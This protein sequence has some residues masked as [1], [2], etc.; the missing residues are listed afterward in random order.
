MEIKDILKLTADEIF[1]YIIKNPE[2]END[3]LNNLKLKDRTKFFKLSSD[4][5]SYKLNSK[6][7]A[8]LKKDVLDNITKDKSIILVDTSKIKPNPGQPR[9]VFDEDKLRE[10]SESVKEHGLLQPI[11]VVANNN[12]TFTLIAGERRLRAHKLANIAEIKAIVLDVDELES[13]KL[14]IIENLHRDDLSAMELGLSYLELQKEGGYSLR[15]LE[16]IVK[17]DK[18]YIA[19]RIN[20]TR[21]DDDCVDFILK[22]NINN[23][24]KLLRILETEGT[25][26][27]TLLEKL[28]KN[29][30]KNED[31]EK[32]NVDKITKLPDE[33]Q[34]QKPS[35]QADVNHDKFD[36]N[37]SFDNDKKA[38]NMEAI[39]EKVLESQKETKTDNTEDETIVKQTDSF[40]IKSHGD[41][42]NITINKTKITGKDLEVILESIKAI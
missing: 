14:A 24:S 20:L 8:A 41:I 22:Q 3:I 37:P 15:D 13:R 38:A 25:V 18:N 29:E 33:K 11:V 30:L 17:K 35:K 28:S 39:T 12:N 21:F 19:A 4:L 6:G 40:L 5:K 23:V 27:K 7:S 31:I 32:F 2:E 10:L 36:E 1:D 16:N 34:P 26:H 9:R 42:L